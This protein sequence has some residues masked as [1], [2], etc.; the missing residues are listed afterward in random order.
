MFSLFNRKEKEK[1]TLIFDIQSSV[2]RGALVSGMRG[3]RPSIIHSCIIHVPFRT[4]A[5]SSYL[6]KRTMKAVSDV[7]EDTHRFMHSL[8]KKIHDRSLSEVHFV[9]SSPWITSQAQVVSINK[10][11]EVKV[12]EDI[13]QQIIDTQR[14]KMD[15]DENILAVIEEKVF[16]VRLNG[17]SVEDWKDK[18]A[19]NIEVSYTSSYANKHVVDKF[20]DECVRFISKSHINFHSTLLLQYMGI[21]N[22]YEHTHNYCIIYLHGELT[23]IVVVKNGFPI[24]FGSFPFGVLTL[25]RKIA[26]NTKTDTGTAESM[27]SLLIGNH[28]DTANFESTKNIIDEITNGWKGELKKM[29]F[30][31]IG[32]LGIGYDIIVSSRT[33]EDYFLSCIRSIYQKARVQSLSSDLVQEKVSFSNKGE[34]IRLLALY[35]SALTDIKP[36]ARQ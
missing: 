22:I 31:N 3:R 32:E 21:S 1:L 15:S 23:D 36:I 10:K 9:L 17:Y 8:D 25:I 5:G 33:H 6:I 20:A 2:V 4:S 34:H 29:L 27:L 28:T 16:D 19:E 35:A 30:S 12:D 11:H 13:V 24:F 18:D 26:K 14:E 7:L